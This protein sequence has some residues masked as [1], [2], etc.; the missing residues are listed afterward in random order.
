MNDLMNQAAAGNHDALDALCAAALER[1]KD[2]ARDRG[3]ALT[4]AL[5]F[6]R[7]AASDCSIKRV[8]HLLSVI[9]LL[10]EECGECGIEDEAARLEGEGLLIMNALAD[11][12]V[13]IAGEAIACGAD[14]ARFSKKALQYARAL[15]R[16][17]VSN[18]KGDGRG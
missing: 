17:S 11:S 7:L 6:A 8:G 4:E 3:M 5:V 18:P 15:E 2:E 9:A 13:E 1:A 14:D 12:G 16:A 10:T